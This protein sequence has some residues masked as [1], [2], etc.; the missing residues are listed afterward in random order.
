MQNRYRE[1]YTILNWAF[2]KRLGTT[3]QWKYFVEDPMKMAQKN[4]AT[5]QEVSFVI[6][7]L[8][9]YSRIY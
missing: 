4:S 8:H 6:C 7:R 5:A 2:P 9:R 1:L 3:E